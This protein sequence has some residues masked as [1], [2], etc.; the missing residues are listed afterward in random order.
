MWGQDIT[1]GRTS[2]YAS[3][4][5]GVTTS[6]SSTPVSTSTTRSSSTTS[7]TS[8]AIPTP[9]DYIV[10]G[11][12]PGGIVAADRLSQAGKKVLLLER[13]A[14]STKETG[15]TRE[16]AP[17]AKTTGVRFSSAFYMRYLTWFSLPVSIF[18]ACLKTCSELPTH[19]GGARI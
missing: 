2:S 11:G 10:V 4:Y 13:G 19:G 5:G 15:G 7:A 3:Y 12:G 18:L 14:A 8:T 9:Y 16:V 1:S 6:V 17:W